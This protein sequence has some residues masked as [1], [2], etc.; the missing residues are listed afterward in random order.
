MLVVRVGQVCPAVDWPEAEAKEETRRGRR[1][2][3][4]GGQGER[5]GLEQISYILYR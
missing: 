3:V 1:G 5:E 4:G 2:R